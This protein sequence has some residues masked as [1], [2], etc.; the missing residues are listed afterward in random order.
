M[1]VKID[2]EGFEVQALS[3]LDFEGLFRPR[4]ILMEFEPRFSACTWR[5]T[6][7]MQAF[8]ASRGYEALTVH[9]RSLRDGDAL[10]ESNVWLRDC[11]AKPAKT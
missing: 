2:V 11:A 3:G 9:G 5:S 6:D 10:P 8:F 1:L 4:H 7:E